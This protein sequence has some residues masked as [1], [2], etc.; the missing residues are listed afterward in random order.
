MI[1]CKCHKINL[2]HEG[3]YIDSLDWIKNKQ[4][5]TNPVN[6]DNKWCQYAA[7]VALNNE[8]IWKHLQ[9]ISKI[10]S[11]ISKYKWKGINYPSGKDDWKSLRKTK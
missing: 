1:P 9:R 5:T 2:S 4:A 7:T 10:K 3:S 11:I 6:D 8:E